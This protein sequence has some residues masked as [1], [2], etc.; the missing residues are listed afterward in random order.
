MKRFQMTVEPKRCQ[1]EARSKRVTKFH[2]S[3]EP[4]GEAK[5]LPQRLVDRIKL[6]EFIKI[7]N[8][9]NELILFE[10]NNLRIF[11]FFSF[12]TAYFQ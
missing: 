3:F 6:N 10:K 12:I 7:C 8:N 5:R 11:S 1:K 9:K 4:N 2:V